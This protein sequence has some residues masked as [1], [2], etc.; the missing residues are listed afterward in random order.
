MMR[1]GWWC[2]TMQGRASFRWFASEKGGFPVHPHYTKCDDSE[3]DPYFKNR[4]HARFRRFAP[5]PNRKA[6]GLLFF[7]C[8]RAHAYVRIWSSHRVDASGLDGWETIRLVVDDRSRGMCAAHKPRRRP[9][10]GRAWV[11]ADTPGRHVPNHRVSLVNV[12][13]A[14]G[15]SSDL[16]KIWFR[17]WSTYV[18]KSSI[19]DRGRK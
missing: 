16:T 15:V 1:K 13:T 18:H 3:Q 17:V 5:A 11:A 10:A 9:P 8:C 4:S 2:H 19:I 6:S 14:P 7:C 12:C